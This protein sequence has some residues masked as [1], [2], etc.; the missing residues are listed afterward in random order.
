M[1][2]HLSGLFSVPLL[3]P[4]ALNE[5]TIKDSSLF[6]AELL[7]YDS[8]LIM[9]S[10]DVESL[11]TN[12]PLQEI[13]DLCVEILFNHKSNNDSFTI[14]DFHGLL[15]VTMPESLVLFDGEHYKQ[16]DGVAMGSPLGP[17]LANI[18]LSYHEQIWLNNCPCEFKAV[19]YKIYV[20]DT[21]L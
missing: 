1:V 18:F 15:T 4:L 8:N 19:I 20:D 7:N 13:N 9:A 2:F 17:T 14:T 3:T 11:F 21:S 16:I 10:F 5:H 6:A 12:T